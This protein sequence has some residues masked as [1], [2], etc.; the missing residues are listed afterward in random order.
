MNFFKRK[1]V[2]S[3]FWVDHA[4]AAIWFL[5]FRCDWSSALVIFYF[6]FLLF[7]CG[8]VV[9]GVTPPWLLRHD[10]YLRPGY[11]LT[12][13]LSSL[14]SV[15]LFFVAIMTFLVFLVCEFF[16]PVARVGFI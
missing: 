14:C 2:H 12:L 9:L 4:E 5:V 11:D 6:Q 10:I 13:T 15:A 7:W 1:I 3:T 8:S 16:Y